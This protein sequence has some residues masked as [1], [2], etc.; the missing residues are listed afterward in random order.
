VTPPA[1]LATISDFRTDAET[2][3]GEAKRLLAA[4]GQ[5]NLRFT[6]VNRN[7]VMPDGSAADYMIE[8]WKQIGVTLTQTKLSTMGWE[9]ASQ[10]EFQA[11]IDFG[12]DY[13]DDSTLPLAKYVSS[14]LSPSNFSSSTDRLLDGL[15]VGRP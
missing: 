10:H 2:A 8:S 5:S 14:D 9:G 13:F 1:D 6:P 3:R 4:A 12:G 15:Y 11:A 7:I